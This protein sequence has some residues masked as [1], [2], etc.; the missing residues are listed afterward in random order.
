[1]NGK[2]KPACR[3]GRFGGKEH[4]DEFDINTYDCGARNGV[5]PE[6][7]RGNPALG[8]RRTEPVEVWMNIDPL[9]EMMTRHSPYNYAFDNPV[10]FI[11][12]DGMMGIGFVSQASFGTSDSFIEMSGG[13]DLGGSGSSGSGSEEPPTEFVNEKGETIAN[14]D[15]GNKQTYV[16]KEGNEDD[17]TKEMGEMVETKDDLNP[18][19]NKEVGDK[20]GYDIKDSKNKVYEG[21]GEG[22]RQNM[23]RLGYID[24]YR[25]EATTDVGGLNIMLGRIKF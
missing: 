23:S 22:H 14:T 5:Y 13:G 12:P 8:R 4:W 1:M 3:Q 7:S 10:Y 17:F 6:R 20:Y 21:A 18:E 16:I 24:G 9:A 11:D 2:Y 25:G 19:K 15:D